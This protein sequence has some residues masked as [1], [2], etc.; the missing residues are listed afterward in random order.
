MEPDNAAETL[1]FFAKFPGKENRELFF[2]IKEISERDQG[3]LGAVQGSY[4]VSDAR[5]D[6]LREPRTPHIHS[7]GEDRFR[8]ICNDTPGDELV[9]QLR[10]VSPWTKGDRPRYLEIS[11]AVGRSSS[12]YAISWTAGADSRIPRP[13]GRALLQQDFRLTAEIHS[14][15]V[16][17]VARGEGRSGPFGF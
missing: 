16:A 1:G 7:G 4:L 9:L 3:I 11:D 13:A 15:A 5:S 12:A 10:N 14:T 6:N 8:L 17:D 2:I